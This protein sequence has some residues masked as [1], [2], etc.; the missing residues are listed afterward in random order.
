MKSLL[1]IVLHQ[2]YRN[3]Q[4]DRIFQFNLHKFILKNVKFY[5]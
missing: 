2:G 5:L 1:A 3:T 4:I